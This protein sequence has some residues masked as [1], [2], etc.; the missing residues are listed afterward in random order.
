VKRSRNPRYVKQYRDRAGTWINQYRRA[1]K[2]FRLPNGRS[3]TEAWWEAYYEAERQFLAGEVRQVGA[4]RT[5][6]GSI[7]AALAGYY[8]STSFLNLAEK[9]RRTLRITWN[10]TSARLSGLRRLRI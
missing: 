5:K 8:R 4:A 1:G 3:F 6:P 7:D 10:V 2:L 9:S